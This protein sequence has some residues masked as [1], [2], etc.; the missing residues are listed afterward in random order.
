[1]NIYFTEDNTDFNYNEK[2]LKQMNLLA[3]NWISDKAPDT[4]IKYYMEKIMEK[5]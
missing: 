5:F 2:Q 1:M 4:V 3:N